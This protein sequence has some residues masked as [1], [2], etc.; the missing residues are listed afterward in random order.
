MSMGTTVTTMTTDEEGS[1]DEVNDTRSWAVEITEH[2]S[3]R[4]KSSLAW[5]TN[6]GGTKLTV[7]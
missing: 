2:Q 7:Y 6:A 5:E 4:Y 3:K 1:G